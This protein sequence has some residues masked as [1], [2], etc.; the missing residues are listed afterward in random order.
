MTNLDDI[1]RRFFVMNL[2]DGILPVLGIIITYFIVFYDGKESSRF[3]LTYGNWHYPRLYES[4]CHRSVAAVARGI[5][6]SGSCY[7]LDKFGS[8]IF[9]LAD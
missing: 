5:E 1:A 2:F 6:P 7:I 3:L 4:F 8:K 9:L